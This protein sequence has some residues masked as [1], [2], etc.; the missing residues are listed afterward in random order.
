MLVSLYVFSA[1]N[2]SCLTWVNLQQ[3]SEAL[4]ETNCCSSGSLTETNLTII[5]K[6][7]IATGI[8]TKNVARHPKLSTIPP[9][10]IK[11]IIAPPDSVIM[12]Y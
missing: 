4:F 9:P 1:Y 8:L 5:V 12:Q 11:P 7:I 2:I 10:I 6:S 3:N